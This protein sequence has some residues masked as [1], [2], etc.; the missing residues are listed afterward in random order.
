M[1]HIAHP[2]LGG[3][4]T[5][6]TLEVSPIGD[7]AHSATDR[8]HVAV[9]NRHTTLLAFVGT[10]HELHGLFLG[11]HN[12]LVDAGRSEDHRSTLIIPGT[13]QPA[14]GDDRGGS[15]GD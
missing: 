3:L 8:Y 12:V 9:V 1:P 4:D 14:E 7:V 5:N 11:L 13:A 10:G 15:E 2:V 6:Y